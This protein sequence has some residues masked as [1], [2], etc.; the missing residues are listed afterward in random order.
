[1]DE[2]FHWCRWVSSRDRPC[3]W[4]ACGRVVST[5]RGGTAATANILVIMG[6][7]IGYW[8]VSAYNRG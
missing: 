2:G 1:M 3:L 5:G 7:D 8:D 6:D 4:G